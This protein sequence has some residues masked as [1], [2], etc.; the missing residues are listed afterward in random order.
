[1]EQASFRIDFLKPGKNL[2]PVKGWLAAIRKLKAFYL[3]FAKQLYRKVSTSAT[4]LTISFV[5]LLVGALIFRS[6]VYLSREQELR[7]KAQGITQLQQQVDA[8]RG[9]IK[10][11]QARAQARNS[12]LGQLRELKKIN[13][14]WRNRLLGVQRN[15]LDK[16]WLTSLQVKD[17]SDPVRVVFQGSSFSSSAQDKPLRLVADFINNLVADA[18]WHKTFSLKDWHVNTLP[19]GKGELVNFEV[20]LEGK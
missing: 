15:M 12:R 14:R 4:M 1:M 13:M 10:Q 3:R 11:Q 18:A 7:A 20:V 2:V 9:K 8:L 5:L 17:G 6:Q 16:L 19:Q